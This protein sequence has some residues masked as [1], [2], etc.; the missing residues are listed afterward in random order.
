[1]QTTPRI[2]VTGAGGYIG[3]HVVSALDGCA[4]VLPAVVD[5]QRADLLDAGQRRQM[6][7]ALKP[8]LLVH[9]AWVTD[10]GAFWSSP[11]NEA[12]LNASK[13]L[14]NLFYANGGR[15]ALATGSCAEYDWTTGADRFR[16]DAPLAP[17]TAYGAA[18]VEAAE[19]LAK[20][21]DD[22]GG[23]WAWGRVFF[24]FGV[25]EPEKRLI[26]AMLRAVHAREDIGI[27]PSETVRDF[28]PVETLGA[29]IAALALSN[30]SGPV[31]LGAGRGTRYADLAALIEEIAGTRGLIKPDSRSLGPGEP[32]VLVP[33]VTNLVEDVGFRDQSDLKSALTRYYL[34]LD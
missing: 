29:S 28:W 1:M 24:S 17:H 22:N 3:R 34:A 27:G 23:E 32:R 12:W 31:N 15:L 8:D 6:I 11:M 20:T 18:K 19:A 26:S 2:L 10:H 5:G 16:E 13:D 14:F 9:L 21:A 4:T 30:V 7:E 25:G 33:D